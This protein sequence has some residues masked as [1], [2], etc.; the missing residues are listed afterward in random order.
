MRPV[1]EDAL[2]VAG[3]NECALQQ[4][5]VGSMVGVGC[6]ED[7]ARHRMLIVDDEENVRK[8]LQ[9][10][11]ERTDFDVDIAADGQ[12][13]VDLC[14][15][16]AYDVITMDIEMPRMNG[17]EAIGHI[18]TLHPQVPIVILTGFSSDIQGTRY[19]GAQKVLNKPMSL[20]DLEK[21]VRELL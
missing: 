16:N 7:V 11:F 12:A 17:I 18:R 1:L 14:R 4:A 20:R 5:K 9:S 2:R 19:A 21:E 3:W 13:A 15:D 6:F 10:W 8:T